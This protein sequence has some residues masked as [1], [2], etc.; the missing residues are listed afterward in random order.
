[1][2]EYGAL[3][4]F[5]SEN[6]GLVDYVD[7]VA[8]ITFFSSRG[9]AELRK[10]HHRVVYG[11]TTDQEGKRGCKHTAFLGKTRPDHYQI[12]THGSNWFS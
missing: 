8:R 4:K 3:V 9:G 11:K 6:K 5:K 2:R 10:F 7:L 1:M 12:T